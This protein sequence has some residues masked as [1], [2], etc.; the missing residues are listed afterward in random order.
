MSVSNA[1][2]FG[3]LLFSGSRINKP[4]L[5]MPLRT[6]RERIGQSSV[7]VRE[8]L[9]NVCEEMEHAFGVETQVVSVDFSGTGE[10]MSHGRFREATLIR[11]ADR[12]P[13]T[14][15]MAKFTKAV[16]ADNVESAKYAKLDDIAEQAE[17]WKSVWKE[18]TEI[19]ID[20][21]EVDEELVLQ[22]YS[23]FALLVGIDE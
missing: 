4:F 13:L 23:E 22:R 19:A 5:A 2:A 15:Y 17:E 16:N 1:V 9:G 6:M 10:E 11:K 18:E 7:A 3:E 12:K 20:Y 21:G 8:L 14:D